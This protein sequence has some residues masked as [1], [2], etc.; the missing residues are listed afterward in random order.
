MNEFDLIKR[1]FH[2]DHHGPSVIVGNGDDGAVFQTP[3]GRQTVISVDALVAG[4]HVPSLCPPEGFAARLLGRGLSDLAAMG[5]DPRYFLLSLTLPNFDAAWVDQFSEKLH[6]LAVQW[7]VDLIGGDTSKGPLAAHV[8]VIGEIDAGRALGRSGALTGDQLWLVGRDLGGARAYLEVLEDRADEHAAW[9]ERYWRP[10]PLLDA[11]RA[12]VG[13]AHAVI[14]ISDGLCQD[15][16][17]LL[18]AA[19]SPLRI[20]LDSATL[21]LAPG[22]MDQFDEHQALEFALTGGDDYCL[23]AAIPVGVAAPH[24]AVCLGQFEAADDAVI[25]LDDRPLPEDWVLGW[26]HSR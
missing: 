8:T 5:A 7:G 11:G 15:L 1:Y 17:H 14:D 26:D 25:L 18:S 10:E 6:Q 3:D 9:A 13:C 12:L 22:L 21:P 19:A 23:L 2:R 16:D 20:S 24:G 4:R